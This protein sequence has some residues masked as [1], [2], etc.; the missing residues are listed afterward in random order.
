MTSYGGGNH[1]AERT[2]MAK[3]VTDTAEGL[4]MGHCRRGGGDRRSGIGEERVT[5]LKRL[6]LKDMSA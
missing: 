5:L 2:D 1:F 4:N 3:V 6:S